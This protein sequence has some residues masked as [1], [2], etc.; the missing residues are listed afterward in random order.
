M[1]GTSLQEQEIQ[2]RSIKDMH[3]NVSRY[4][5]QMFRRSDL[6]SSGALTI[7]L[8]QRWTFSNRRNH[9]KNERF[10]DSRRALV[11]YARCIQ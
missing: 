2:C 8:T 1:L 10:F 4:L 3:A 7:G 9:N 6:L 5:P 11:N